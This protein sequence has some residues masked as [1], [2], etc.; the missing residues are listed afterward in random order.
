VL[1]AAAAIDWSDL[2][3]RIGDRKR[4][5]A[6][7]TLR[8]IRA[9]LEMFGQQPAIVR[10]NGG[11]PDGS[12]YV[13]ARPASVSP[14]STV[15]TTRDE[16]LATPPFLT[17]LRSGRIR[18]IGV[19]DE[20]LA[21]I[22]AGGSNHGLVLPLG[23]YNRTS[24]PTTTGEPMR[25]RVV[26]D[27]DALVTPPFITMLRNNTAPTPADEPMASVLA[28]GGH[29]GGHH[30]LTIPPFLLK[31]YGGYCT[32]GQ[33]ISAVSD[34]VSAVT[35]R[36]GHA[37][38]VPYRGRRSRATTTGE[39]LHTLATRDSAA[40]VQ[41][42]DP[43][44]NECRLRMLKPREHLRAQRF[45]DSYIVTGNQGEQTMQ[46]G[47]AVSANVAHWLGRALAEVL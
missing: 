22:M 9:G 1:P 31:N 45:P 24:E 17:L 14:L 43:E 13:R 33:N 10:A 2:G 38:V 40:L 29:G 18:T 35:V 6:A 26:R 37:L 28:I 44:V 36:D 15:T 8:R 25:T 20:P 23:G 11:D 7:N 47:N 32:P 41:P 46:A 34:P 3:T 4:P 27:T 12:A 21:A 42:D 19:D 30:A 39:P 5:L 16:A